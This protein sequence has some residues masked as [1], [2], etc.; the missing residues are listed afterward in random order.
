MNLVR[1]IG[2]LT[3][4]LLAMS[5]SKAW[6]GSMV[7][8]SGGNV[9]LANEDGSQPFQ[10]T[11]DG[12]TANPDQTAY[13]SPTEADDGTIVAAKGGELI[14]L[15]QNGAVI[16]RFI[17]DTHAYPLAAAV[18]PD[19]RHIAYNYSEITQCTI[20]VYSCGYYPQP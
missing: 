2:A 17:P 11:L 18:S 6:A 9:F 15:A 1:W 3:L 13:R 7:Y 19:G 10:V 20:Y 8:I 14:H 12:S 16:S 4:A 5:S